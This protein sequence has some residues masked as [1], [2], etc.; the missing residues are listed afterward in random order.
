MNDK[1]VILFD[2]N[3]AAHK[4][5]RT[6]EGWVSSTG[7]FFAG[8]NAEHDA[9]Y[10]G[11]TNIKCPICGEVYEKTYSYCPNCNDREQ[12]EKYLKLPK[13][14]WDEKYPLILEDRTFGSLD[15]LHDYCENMECQPSKMEL[16][17]TE[18]NYANEIEV[19]DIYWDDYAEDED[20]DNFPELKEQYEKLNTWIREH[21]IILSYGAINK[22]PDIEDFED[23]GD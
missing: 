17:L 21:P 3:E 23:I 1:K 22:R 11:C 4:E 8:Y 5:T 2:S 10:N 9:R 12:H 14:E 16:Y 13:V 7:T 19:N 6:L 20:I 18:P 15:E